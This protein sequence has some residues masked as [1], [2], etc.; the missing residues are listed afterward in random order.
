MSNAAW[1]LF[2]FGIYMI[3]CGVCFALLANELLPLVG[4]PPDQNPTEPWA[5]ICGVIIAI[6]GCYYLISAR[7]ELIP[8]MWA[9][10]WGRVTVMVVYVLFVLLDHVPWKLILFAV[11]DQF[12]ALWTCLA[13]RRSR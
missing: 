13:L 10:V 4:F 8:F 9:T 7:Y 12:G 5:R 6:L 1:S 11:P 3:L 2:V